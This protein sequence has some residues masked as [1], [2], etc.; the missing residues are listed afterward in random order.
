MTALAQFIGK[1]VVEDD[2]LHWKS[3]LECIIGNKKQV[4]YV[5]RAARRKV[6]DGDVRG[7]TSTALI[8]WM[9][10]TTK[11]DDKVHGVFFI[12]ICKNDVCAYV[13]L[14]YIIFYNLFDVNMII[15]PFYT[16]TQV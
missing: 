12:T 3:V 2:D 14:E 9:K 10:I 1:E 7:L 11:Q 6:K 15:E 4:D 16:H 5:V 8:D 13:F